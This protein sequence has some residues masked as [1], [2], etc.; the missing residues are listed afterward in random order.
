MIHYNKNLGLYLYYVLLR[1]IFFFVV[2]IFFEY[3]P[4]RNFCRN[5]IPSWIEL[6]IFR[7]FRTTSNHS[8]S[9]N[10]QKILA[11]H[12]RNRPRTCSELNPNM[13]GFGPSLQTL[14]SFFTVAVALHIKFL[15]LQK[16]NKLNY[17]AAFQF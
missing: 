12:F 4:K 3:T 17:C 5:R 16:I 2:D 6:L 14:L 9:E 8:A 13:F 7:N 10:V 11:E 15:L 1:K